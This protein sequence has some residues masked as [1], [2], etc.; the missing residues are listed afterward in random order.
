MNS[1]YV[2]NSVILDSLANNKSAAPD[3]PYRTALTIQLWPLQLAGLKIKFERLAAGWDRDTFAEAARFDASTATTT[4]QQ[5][6]RVSVSAYFY[7]ANVDF[8][9]VQVSDLS[10]QMVVS[11]PK[12]QECHHF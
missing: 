12:N 11:K 8:W 3:G 6:G 7:I 5:H 10:L 1:R 4:L 9:N 2:L